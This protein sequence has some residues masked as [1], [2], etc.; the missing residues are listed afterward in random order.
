MRGSDSCR[1]PTDNVGEIGDQQPK[2]LV[3]LAGTPLIARQIAALRS[4]GVTEIGD[5][6]RFPLGNDRLSGHNLFRK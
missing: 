2:C 6:A 3:P 1:R 5:R 4:G